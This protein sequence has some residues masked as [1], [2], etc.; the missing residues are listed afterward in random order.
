LALALA[1]LNMGVSVWGT[2]FFV[3]RILGLIKSKPPSFIF[4]FAK[5]RKEGR[6]HRLP[7]FDLVRLMR[8]RVTELIG[9]S[10]RIIRDVCSMTPVCTVNIDIKIGLTK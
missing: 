4:G 2:P 6:L 5:K 7:L 1:Y 3:R 10:M 8:I 9:V